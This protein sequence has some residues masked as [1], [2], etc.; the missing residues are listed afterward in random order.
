MPTDPAPTG[1]ATDAAATDAAVAG[2]TGTDPIEAVLAHNRALA[3]APEEAVHAS[4]P[5]APER[6]LAI[7]TCMD[8]RLD[9]PAALGL[10]VGEAHLIRNAGGLVTDDV[11]RSLVI[12]Q[13]LLG[14][15]AIL[16]AHHT[17]C[18]ML[19][20]DEAA[21]HAELTRDAGSPPPFAAGSFAD[22]DASVR[23]SLG[24]VGS[25]PFLPHRDNVRGFVYDVDT[26]RLREVTG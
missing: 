16:L 26:H 15:D 2:G 14:T 25:C 21:F 6:R 4:L 11:I 23:T 1:A 13:R 5:A 17:G 12:S 22:L 20:F 24:R 9:L 8:A 3:A 10:R 18:G 7:V 19:A